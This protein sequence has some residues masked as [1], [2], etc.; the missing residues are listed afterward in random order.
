MKKLLSLFSLQE[1]KSLLLKLILPSK[2]KIVILFGFS[3]IGMSFWEAVTNAIAKYFDIPFE[4][5]NNPYY[6]VALVIIGLIYEGY[7]YYIDNKKFYEKINTSIKRMEKDFFDANFTQSLEDLDSYLLEYV[8]NK[9]ATYQLLVSKTKF[10]LDLQKFDEFKELIEVVE[11]E[12]KDYVD[13]KFKELK[14]T[15]LALEKN[16]VFFEESKQLRLK[17]PKSKPQGHFD[18]V[19]YLNSKNYEKAKEI[20]EVEIKNDEFRK[21]LLILGGHIYSNLYQY[22]GEDNLY[23]ELA[24]KYYKEALESEEDLSFTD[25]LHI[26]GFYGTVYINNALRHKKQNIDLKYLEEYKSLL[27]VVFENKKYFAISYVNSLLE[28]Y[29]HALLALGLIEEYKKVYDENSKL[30]PA[31]FYLQYCEVSNTAFEHEQV[32]AYIKNDFNINDL[33]IYVSFVNNESIDD[34]KNIVLFLDNNKDF[35]YENHFVMYCYVKGVIKL[36]KKIDDEIVGYIEENKYLSIDLLLAFLDLQKYQKDK[37]ESADL[38]K[39]FEF[40]N[41]EVNFP[42]RILDAM[43]FLHSVGNRSYLKIALDK[44][45]IFEEL[46]YEALKLCAT[47][48]DLNFNPFNTFVN[49]IKNKEKVY[50]HIANNYQNFN[51]LDKA[52]DYFFL[53]Y[54]KN[55]D[56]NSMFAI[57]HI[58]LVLYMQSGEKYESKKQDNV[59]S[60]FLTEV[61]TLEFQNLLFLLSYEISVRHESKD[62]L[63][64]I[65]QKLL[66]TDINALSQEIKIGLSN[67]YLQTQ[68]LFPN[69]EKIFLTDKNLCYEKDGIAYVDEQYSI[70]EENQK[71]YGFKPVT[72]DKFFVI[73]QDEMYKKTSLFHRIVGPFAFRVDNPNLVTF[74]MDE[75]KED[76]LKDMLDFMKNQGVDTKNLFER[77][78]VGKEIGLYPLSQSNY[79]NYFTLIPYL[80]EHTEFNL[81][82]GKINFKPIEVKKILTLSSIVLLHNLNILDKVLERDDVFIQRTMLNWLKEYSSSITFGNMPTDFSYLDE[83]EQKPIL[84]VD[85]QDDIDSFKQVVINLLG[86]LIEKCENKIIDDHLE[87]LPTKNSYEIL[88]QHIG[89]QEYQAFAYCI[90]HN[91]QIISEDSIFNMLFDVMKFNK[92]FIS[93]SLILVEETIEYEELRDL[94]ID[95]Y[96]KNYSEVI[97]DYYLQNLLEYM[98]KDDVSRLHMQEIELIKIANSYGW[99]EDI[100]R[101]YN[102]KFVGKYVKTNLATPNLLDVNIEKVLEII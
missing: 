28:N 37:L 72:N 51:K 15:L 78:S 26:Y 63:H 11:K 90:N 85:T 7:I 47:D 4:Y 55:K 41:L 24:D 80:L 65:N 96:K 27:D 8:K 43:I 50:W 29:L 10:S 35:I 97:D 68:F 77:Y 20:F 44:Q 14:I 81:N 22:A 82:A 100:K 5:T 99:L 73:S 12:Y 30:L 18:L 59:F 45:D 95:L 46:I 83:L 75:T 21:H 62:I 66:E 6:G 54:E 92:T 25:K 102:N 89:K 2:G 87:I 93:N 31:R 13:T 23:F 19:Y 74:Q 42:P 3:L 36:N 53:G 84:H 69:Y 64:L 70:V 17:T 49:A 56:L 76:P 94:K 34:T 48:R 33:L 67:F 71:N 32:Q 1:L 91:Y 16:E 98:N 60:H 52:F 101:Y 9:E 38:E 88:S 57:L 39:L 86:M 58:S 79:R 61:D 40:I